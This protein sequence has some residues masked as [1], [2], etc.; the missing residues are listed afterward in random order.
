MNK[1]YDIFGGRKMFFAIVLL[2]IAS[3]FVFF[4]KTDFSG[5]SEFIKWVFGI[6]ALGNGAE[7]IGNLF[8]NKE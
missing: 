2:I 8:K 3:A 6:F 5:W 1:I 4:D 7:H